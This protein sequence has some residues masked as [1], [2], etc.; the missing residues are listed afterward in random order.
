[1]KI[2]L[3]RR[4][5]FTLIELLVVI[6]II[7]IL[8]G[9]LLPAVQKVRE[10][11]ARMTCQN[12]L[13][14]ICLAAQNFDSANQVL[15]P[16]VVGHNSPA[17]ANSGFTWNAPGIGTLV[18]LLPFVEQDN[19]FKQLT[20]TPTLNF[21]TYSAGMGNY[22]WYA[23]GSYWNA[24]QAKI[25]T[26]LCPA[27]SPESNQ[28]GVFITLYTDATYLVFTGG[29]YP[30]P[31]GNVLGKC[32]YAPSAGAIGDG[33]NAGWSAYKGPF[34]DLSLNSVSRIPDGTSNT[35]F[36]GETLCGTNKGARDFAL[37]WMG[38]GSMA[39]YWGL[40][41][42]SQWYTYGSRH[43][44]NATMFG[45]GDGSVRSMKSGLGAGSTPWLYATGI[46]EGGV[47]NFDNL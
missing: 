18:Y 21:Q 4:T 46:M 24:A 29:Y 9:L 37:S 3:A 36:F 38:A 16:G 12:N 42:P 44:N 40:P 23:N 20:P 32:N 47:I 19:L 15:P 13:K 33:S 26:F 25:K 43:T 35:V 34:N 5:G 41:Y 8:I 28:N 39:T 27:D 7:A 30:N 10:A 1:M 31:T 17:A 22:H 2:P 14:Q 6:A 11:A 45:Y